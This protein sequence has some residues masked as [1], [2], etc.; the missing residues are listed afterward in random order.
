MQ[1][2]RTQWLL[3]KPFRVYTETNKENRLFAWIKAFPLPK[4]NNDEIK[5]SEYE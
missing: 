1:T 4:N 2:Y 5:N 3:Q